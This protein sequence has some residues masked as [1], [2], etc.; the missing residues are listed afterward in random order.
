M[1]KFNNPL[2]NVQIAAPCQA[3]WEDM[4]G[5]EQRRY[6]AMCQLNVYNL[7]AMTRNEAEKLISENEGRLCVRFYRRSDGTIITQNC[8]K[9]IAALKRRLSRLSTAA[10]SAAIAFL[11][12]FGI[13]SAFSSRQEVLGKT[14]APLDFNEPINNT[15]LNYPKYEQTMGAISVQ[16]RDKVPVNNKPQSG[17]Y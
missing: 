10:L 11:S 17:R 3:N 6:C 14:V 12:G 5:T 15:D 8:P 2:D 1:P 7:S 4:N 13:S 16:V 9:G